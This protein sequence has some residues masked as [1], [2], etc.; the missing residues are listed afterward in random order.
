MAPLP[1]PVKPGWVQDT[2]LYIPPTST[3]IVELPAEWAAIDS[4][5]L[6]KAMPRRIRKSLGF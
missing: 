3:A 5:R 4:R 2:T 6:V 1:H